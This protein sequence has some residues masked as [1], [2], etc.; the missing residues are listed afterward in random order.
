MA[1]VSSM[2]LLVV[3]RLAAG[4][5][6][7]LAGGGMT[8][9]ERPAAG[10]GIAAAGAVGEEL[11]GGKSSVESHG[12]GRASRFRI[13]DYRNADCRRSIRRSAI[14]NP[15]LPITRRSLGFRSDVH[16]GRQHVGHAARRA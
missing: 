15:Q 3:F 10:P 4:A 14:R 13:A 8:Q 1:A 12:R 2:R 9:D 16:A 11:N 7:L 5:F 6:H